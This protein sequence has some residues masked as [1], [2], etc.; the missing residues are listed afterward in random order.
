[1]T[2]LFADD[3]SLSYSSLNVREMQLLINTDLNRLSEWASRWLIRF[4]PQKTEVML[5]STTHIE[6]TIE[7]RMDN[8]VLDIVNTH[9]HLGVTLS[10]NNKWSNHIDT[11]IKS[12]SKQVSF[13]RKIKYKFSSETLNILYC[14]YIRSLLEYASEV[15][16]G[17]T[18]GDSDRLEKVQLHAARI[19]TG[20]PVFASLNS[21]YYETGWE[22]LAERR[23]KKK[24]TLIYRIVHKDAPT[25]LTDL[26]PNRIQDTSSYNL[27]NN[28]DFQIPFT[29]LCS[30]ESSFYPSSLRLWNNLELQIRNSPPLSHFKNCIKKTCKIVRNYSFEGERVSSILLTR[31]RHNCSSLNADLFRVNIVLNPMCSCGAVFEDANHFFFEC[32]LYTEQRNRLSDS[33]NFIPVVTLDL[34][35]NGNADFTDEINL[36]MQRAVLRYIK[37]TRRFS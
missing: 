26:L 28:Q 32:R 18:Q 6:E 31:I 19:I 15:W 1:M 25:Y 14:S 35:V 24:L 13:L 33:L 16:D 36:N 7:L 10:S 5:I 21:L 2:R 4:N 8:T 30:F 22:T 20:L 27:R 12:A 17:C 37:E 29:R 9:K 34:L 3:T 23:E 11:I